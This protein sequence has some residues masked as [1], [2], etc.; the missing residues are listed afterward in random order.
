M[1]VLWVLAC[2]AVVACVGT[3]TSATSWAKDGDAVGSIVRDGFIKER[4]TDDRDEKE[5][6]TSREGG[7]DGER[8]T[9]GEKR[10]ES[11]REI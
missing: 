3:R 9:K 4:E 5:R 7:E 8:S 11:G 1:C 10:N 2:V 6:E